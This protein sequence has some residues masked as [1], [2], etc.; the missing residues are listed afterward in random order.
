MAD[1]NNLKAKAAELRRALAQ[2]DKLTGRSDE[3]ARDAGRKREER[4]ARSL[5]IIPRCSDR[6]L[7]AALEADDIAWLM[8]CFAEESGTEFPFTYQFTWQQRRMIA[9]LRR[10]ISEGGDQ[11]IAA[12]RGEGKST[13]VQR[14]L[15][16]FVLEGIVKFA[17]LFAATG[18]A[19][20]DALATI[21]GELEN[22]TRLLELYPEVCVPV[23]A[24][25]NVPSRAHYMLVSGFR[26][27][28]DQP[29][30]MHRAKFSWCGPGIKLPNVPGSPAAR[31]LIHT[32]GLE[33]FGR[34]SNKGGRRPDVAVIDDPDTE[35]TVNSIE[36]AKKLEDKIDRVIALLGSQR[37]RVARVLITTIQNRNCVSYRF[38]NRREKP[39]WRGE[40]FRFLVKPPT[41]IE[42]W[43][44]FIALKHDDWQLDTNTAHEFYLSRREAMDAGAEVANP[45]RFT[46]DE[47][48][49]LEFYFVQI[50]RIGEDA[51]AAE[52]DNDPKEEEGHGESAVSSALVA[53]RTSG[54]AQRIVPTNTLAITCG[55]DV[56]N[57]TSHW[58]MVAWLQG[59]IGFI[60]D[61][62]VIESRGA[63]LADNQ[64]ALELAI[65]QSLLGW[66]NDFIVTA[67][68]LL[69][70]T[71]KPYQIKTV[72][73]D[74][75]S[76]G[77]QQTAVYSFVRAVHGEPF[78]AS[79]GVG[80]YRHPK[81]D[82]GKVVLLPGSTHWHLSH[83]PDARLWLVNVDVDHFKSW[84]HERFLTPNRNDDGTP[85]LG[86][87]S[88]FEIEFGDV[89]AKQDRHSFTRHLVAEVW[90]PASV[91]G[92]RLI[93]AGWHV[94]S[95][96]NHWY[97]ALCLAAAAADMNGI[98]LLPGDAIRT[99]AP[100][101]AIPQR[102]PALTMPDG[103]PFLVT[104]RRV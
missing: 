32:Q 64:S 46:G 79:K 61:Y 58:V 66:R 82:A 25:Q 65:R 1:I 100:A 60:I 39:S 86:S 9:A 72:L 8:W 12:S 33:S 91:R 47:A 92:G 89:R 3:R 52:L 45:N 40:R 34:G 85:R 20:K 38:T 70:A 44:E 69:D 88:L 99:M 71:G 19:A 49:A 80:S 97:D 87:L 29:F 11:A 55:I 81:E 77:A 23:R 35:E 6:A 16:K 22:N 48:S 83:Q 26:H 78:Y 37:R 67:P 102:K 84:V 54:L 51:V 7:R 103:R 56:G 101:A 96:N 2:V 50:A 18:D 94:N 73:V 59:A 95:K 41:N 17:M 21:K 90:R 104:Q 24:L 75:G 42:L 68:Q 98:S 30:E 43:H 36:Q 15:L 53:S 14:M 4:E 10:A 5:V 74:S 62:G 63:G 57:I 93:K 31:G 13:L 27:D 76:G 28:N